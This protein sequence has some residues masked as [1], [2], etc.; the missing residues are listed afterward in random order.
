MIFDVRGD[1][2]LH[3]SNGAT[4]ELHI[5]QRFPGGSEP[6]SASEVLGGTAIVRTMHV[7]IRPVTGR[8]TDREFFLMIEWSPDSIGEY[9]GTF[10]GSRLSGITF[11]RKHP[12]SQAT[13]FVDKDFRIF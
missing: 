3:Q 11:D 13:W 1:Y 5:D 6:D 9:H 8:T 10:N 4:V 7:G 2:E 12:S